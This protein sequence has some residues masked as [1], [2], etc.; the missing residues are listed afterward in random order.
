MTII[1]RSAAL[2][3]LAVL[4][5][6]ASDP[7][8]GG[9]SLYYGVNLVDPPTEQITPNAYIAVKDGK[10]ARLG[11][12]A[13]PSAVYASRQDMSGGYAVPG[14]IDTHAHVTL[15]TVAFEA[16]PAPAFRANYDPAYTEHSA[17]MLLAHGVTT[18]RDPGGDTAINVA[19]RNAAASG[20]IDGPEALVAGSVIDRSP[21][22]FEGLSERPDDVRT[23]EDIA[24][25]Q[26]DAGV[27]FVKLY[28]GLTEEDIAHA[29]AAAQA[30]DI[31]T[32]GHLSISWK[33]AAELGVDA[34]VHAMPASVDDLEPSARAAYLKNARPGGFAFFEWWEAADLDGPVMR[35][36]I[37]TLA[38]RKTHIDLTLIAFKLAFWG[39]DPAFR[40]QYLG[41]A[42][43]DMVENWR[44]FFRFDLGWRT[45]D[46]ARAKAVWPKILRFARMLHDAGVPMTLGT[47]QA[48]PF[49]APGASLVQEMKLHED[50]GIARWAALRMATSEAAEILKLDAKTGRI[51]EGLDA[52][53]V[54][55]NSDP[56]RNLDA[57]FNPL[58]V[59]S[60]GRA[61]D[62]AAL[63]KAAAAKPASK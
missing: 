31:Q 25:A 19:Y 43:P 23:I 15:G 55:L 22:P 39:D 36:V 34:I 33:K 58:L 26:A 30:R 56:T 57:F 3:A 61:Y 62:P 49:V 50:A 41:L 42:H 52:D 18:I 24:N 37:R 21:F 47:D 38:E 48:N 46:Y 35:E 60:N 20:A 5:A 8:L 2:F 7:S 29:A 44:A 1:R 28:Y 32:I 14:L 6:C 27:D 12:G 17:R 10:I 63:R 13:P 59:L 16:D 51:A 9:A 45:E 40:D 53:V 54:F 4:S 11:T